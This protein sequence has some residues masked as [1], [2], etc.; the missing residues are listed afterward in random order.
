M[1]HISFALDV[2]IFFKTIEIVLKRTGI[3]SDTSA[4]MEKFVGNDGDC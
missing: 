4:T 2:K 3:S 1:D